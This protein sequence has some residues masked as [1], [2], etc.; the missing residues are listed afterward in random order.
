M[1]WRGSRKLLLAA[2]GLLSA[3]LIASL[4]LWAMDARAFRA[5]VGRDS[6]TLAPYPQT[7]VPEPPQLA[8]EAD[9][10]VISHNTDGRIVV[11]LSRSEYR[12]SRFGRRRWV[13]VHMETRQPGAANVVRPLKVLNELRRVDGRWRVV[14]AREITLP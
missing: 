8:D 11:H 2:A 7:L 3:V 9:A 4:W 12:S 1:N 5:W 6:A 10:A 13:K 14:E